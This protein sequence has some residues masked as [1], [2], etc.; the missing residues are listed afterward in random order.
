MSE[1]KDVRLWEVATGRELASFHGHTAILQAVAFHPDGRRI[2]SGGVDGMVKISDLSHSQPVVFRG[3]TGWVT[4]VA[5]SRDGRR[6]AS[7]TGGELNSRTGDET[8]KVWDPAT[9]EECPSP[10]A[11]VRSPTQAPTS[12]AAESKATPP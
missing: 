3:H 11:Q 4:R 5:F 6:V 10:A 8:I 9:G 1:G 12:A 7:E 2:V